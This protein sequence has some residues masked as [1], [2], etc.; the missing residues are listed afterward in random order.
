M[1]KT[2]SIMLILAVCAGLLGGCRISVHLSRGLSSFYYDNVEKYV[3]GGS[4]ITDTVERVEIQWFSGSV[5]VAAHKEDIVRFS[6]E[7]NR[8]LTNDNSVHYWLDGTTLRIQFCNSGEW[9]LNGLKKDLMVLLPEELMLKELKLNG[10][11]AEI[12][13]DSIHAEELSLNT[14]F[15]DLA[16]TG[17][18]ITESADLDTT[19][20]AVTA[21]VLGALRELCMST[22]SGK[23]LVTAQRID[24]VDMDST[25]GDLLLSV[26]EAPDRI[27]MSTV[28]GAVTLI[29]PEDTGMTLRFN[30]VSGKLSSELPVETD[31]KKSVFGDG[32]CE[33]RV[34]T[35]SGDLKM[36]RMAK[37]MGCRKRLD[38]KPYEHFLC[39]E[40]ME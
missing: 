10:M 35:T 40:H 14:V 15:G 13:V 38:A 27:D 23:A 26:E 37:K 6:E 28:S 3:V 22:V 25:S 30:T 24:M 33:C 20:G 18:T 5:N 16:V 17:C 2:F 11:S 32:S 19:S 31:G 4:G 39:S 9:D 12:E 21:E 1:K 36:G 34:D 7:A 29:L 8:T